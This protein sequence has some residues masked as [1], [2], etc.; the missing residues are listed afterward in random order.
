MTSIQQQ[1]IC[2]LVIVTDP[3]ED[4]DDTFALMLAATSKQY[5]LKAVI[6]ANEDLT[7][8][9]IGRV[10][11][12]ARKLLDAMGRS[13]VPVYQGESLGKHHFLCNGDLNPEDIQK[14]DIDYLDAVN[15][16]ADTYPKVYILGIAAMSSV[17][18][19]TRAKWF[20]PNKFVIY[21]MGGNL[22]PDVQKPEYNIKCDIKAAQ[23]VF[24]SGADIH[25]I[26]SDSTFQEPMM[27]SDESEIFK[28]V[29]S[30][31]KQG[32]RVFKLL[33]QNYHAFRES[34]GKRWGYFPF[35]SDALAFSALEKDF[36]HFSTR[37]IEVLDT[38]RTVSSEKGSKVHVS[39]SVVDGE[40]FMTYLE[41]RLTFLDSVL[42]S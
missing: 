2:P 37:K 27:V 14:L 30:L 38:G 31:A 26:T 41:E 10:A 33:T 18:Y 21:Q 15:C 32:K 40:K 34:I 3:G 13:D 6:S 11:C 7:E 17:A 1:S 16:L 23:D 24:H 9:G 36:V 19:I 12:Y 25:L 28:Q 29:S 8:Q 35:L 4:V 22:I 42:P 39:E 5:S 20:D